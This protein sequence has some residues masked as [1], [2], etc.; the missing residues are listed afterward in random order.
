MFLLVIKS[1]RVIIAI[2]LLLTVFFANAQYNPDNGFLD[3][4]FGKPITF[5]SR[6]SSFS[7]GIGGRI[8]SL[9]ESRYDLNQK[10]GT[11]DCYIR[12]LRLNFAGNAIGQKFTYR[13]QLC[14]SQP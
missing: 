7:L 10:K 1:R 3:A 13:I 12:R 5:S 4:H 8:Q 14:F 2:N 9:A 6:D 11:I